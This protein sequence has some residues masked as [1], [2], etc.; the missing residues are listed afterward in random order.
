MVKTLANACA[1]IPRG[2][3]PN[4][5]LQTNEV[6]SLFQYIHTFI[7]Y[8]QGLFSYIC[9]YIHTH[10][11]NEVRHFKRPMLNVV[12]LCCFSHSDSGAVNVEKTVPDTITKWAAG[13][14]CVSSV[15][16]GISPN[17]GLTA[18]QPFFVSLT[19]P[20][21]VVRGEVFTLK[22]TVFNYLSQCIMVTHD[23]LSAAGIHFSSSVWVC[24]CV[25]CDSVQVNV[26]LADSS[27]FTSRNCDGCQY[28]VCLCDQES[29]TFSWI[30]TPTDLGSKSFSFLFFFN[31]AE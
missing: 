29:K 26:R 10:S 7:Q 5:S 14:F 15:G 21:S 6:W 9:T 27:Q 19:L 30:V 24:C 1:K 2:H 4:I 8:I 28:T 25:S 13:A 20:Y 3:A 23:L 18:F 12:L 22:A 16:L 17:T 11:W 31:Q